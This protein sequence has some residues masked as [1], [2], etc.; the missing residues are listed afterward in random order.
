[1][2]KTYL[3]C[4]T[5]TK[6]IDYRHVFGLSYTLCPE[7]V[8]DVFTQRIRAI[9][10]NT[11]DSNLS[12]PVYIFFREGNYIL[13]GVACLNRELSTEYC[14]ERTNGRVR[15]FIGIVVDTSYEH[16]SSVPLSLD[17][18]EEL[19]KQHI[20]PI[21]ESYTFQY[22]NDRMVNTD[23]L[24]I[25]KNIVASRQTPNINTDS[26]QCRLFSNAWDGEILMS[27]ALGLASNISIALNLD[28]EQQATMPDYYP[29]MNAQ[30]KYSINESFEDVNVKFRCRQ[31]GTL[32]DKLCNENMCHKCWNEKNTPD[33]ELNILKEDETETHTPNDE[34][35]Y[36]SKER[37]I[38]PKYICSK[39]GCRTDELYTKH[40]LCNN[41]YAEYAKRQRIRKILF[42]TFGIIIFISLFLLWF[43]SSW[44]IIPPCFMRGTDSTLVAQDSIEYDSI[45]NN[46]NH[47]NN[48]LDNSHERIL[49]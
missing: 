41:C 44:N 24:P 6:Y 28:N 10:N 29:L 18:Y 11:D 35:C 22:E 34:S 39:C 13:Y 26:K 37:N 45:S 33:S 12:T 21:W 36:N 38:Q 30:M 20:A 9:L 3:Y 15:G 27:E 17:F 42:P 5:R 25:S 40:K 1:M 14:N 2:K 8:Q 16:I 4:Y 47:I 48:R 31:C 32:V 7:D 23:L 19:Y 43:K 46:S 49:Q